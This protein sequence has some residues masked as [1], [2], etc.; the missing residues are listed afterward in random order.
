MVM[1]RFVGVSLD[2]MVLMAADVISTQLMGVAQ[3]IPAETTGI[4]GTAVTAGTVVMAAT[5]AT[6]GTAATVVMAVTAVT[7]APAAALA[8]TLAVATAPR[9]AALAVVMPI[10]ATAGGITKGATKSG[11]T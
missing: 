3:V 6:A 11:R 9:P 8:A 10:L 4:A 2:L 1:L 7:V 5:A